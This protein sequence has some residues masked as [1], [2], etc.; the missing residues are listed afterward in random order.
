MKINK[1]LFFA[2]LCT[3]GLFTSC[4]DLDPLPTGGT[5]TNGQFDQMLETDPEKMGN[6]VIGLY[7]SY[8]SFM[9]TSIALDSRTADFVTINPSQQYS[10]YR[11]NACYLDITATNSIGVWGTAYSMIFDSNLLIASLNNID[12]DKTDKTLSYYR[13]QALANRAFAYMYLAQLYQFTYAKDPMAKGVPV[14]TE[15]NQELTAIEGS[16]R[17]TLQEVYEQIL[18]DLTEGIELM[19]NNSA[20]Q[21]ADKRYFDIN[22]LYGFR[23]RANLLM[24]NYTEAAADAQKVIDSGDFSPLSATQCQVPGFQEISEANWIWGIYVNKTGVGLNNFANSV[25]T[26]CHG[27][28]QAGNWKLIDPAL[29]EQIDNNDPRKLWWIAPVTRESVAN[30]WTDYTSTDNQYTP[31]SYLEEF[32]VPDYTVVKFAPYE[33]E[34]D[35]S[36]KN[37][38]YPLM[39]IEEMWLILAEAKGLDGAS[40][41]PG[42][43]VLENFI[44]TY[45]R[46]TG[47]YTCTATTADEFIDEIYLQRRIEFWGEGIE[48]LDILR[49]QKPMDRRTEIWSGQMG[50][51]YGIQSYAFYNQPTN[52]VM[53]WMLPTDEIDNNPGMTDAD[54]NEPGQPT[55]P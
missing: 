49:L 28:V 9:G 39:R 44:N 17:G 35:Q 16:S 50:A 32:E 13:G 15:K 34:I 37:T 24:H 26:W 12:P 3:T 43:A 11:N 2:S 54:Q 23:A 1:Y 20:A 29:Y 4:I 14:I 46:T 5:F 33:N 18:S 8:S 48:Y 21:R 52:P 30:Y 22:V 31:Q 45:R 47:K 53:I 55:L 6:L 19:S 51:T 42:V 25:N 38:D 40:V 41:A 10:T 7:D 36:M 27:Y